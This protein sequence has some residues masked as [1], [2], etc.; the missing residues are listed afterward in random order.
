MIDPTAPFRTAAPLKVT[1]VWLVNTPCPEP[2][3][4]LVPINLPRPDMVAL[5]EAVV[6]L[7]SPDALPR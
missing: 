2:V 3:K 7:T 4:V 5:P 1:H 6:P